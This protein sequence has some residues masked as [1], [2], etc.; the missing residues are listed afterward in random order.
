MSDGTV[1][2][3]KVISTGFTWTSLFTG[4]SGAGIL[5]LVGLLIRNIG[6]W[7]KQRDEAEEKFRNA[8]SKRLAK[9]EKQLEV[10]RARRE[11]E[12]T[13][14]R[15]K[16]RN[17]TQCLDAVL[18]VLEKAPDKTQEVI[19]EIRLMRDRQMRE[20]AIESATLRAADVAAALKA[21]EEFELDDH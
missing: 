20:E 7:R 1:E 13:M 9:V 12:R 18:L 10:E 16:I 15:H 2:A 5:G 3:V 4:I 8:L 11:A 17:L 6:P 19:A 14:E 21:E